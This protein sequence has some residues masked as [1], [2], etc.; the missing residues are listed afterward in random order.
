MSEVDQI[1]ASARG[2]IE[3]AQGGRAAG[4]ARARSVRGKHFAALRAHVWGKIGRIFVAAGAIL[5]GATLFGAFV[6]PLGFVGSLATL[7]LVGG[8]AMALAVFPR[9]KAPAPEDLTRTDIKAIAGQTEIWLES[10]RRALPAP[11]QTMVDAIGVQLDL[12]APQLQ[13]LDPQAP[14]AH[15]IRRLLA[16]DLTGLVAGYRAVP[17]PL[18]REGRNGGATPDAQLV[19][20]LKLIEREVGDMARGLAAGQLDQLATRQRY[21]EIKYQ[22]DGAAA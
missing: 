5:V 12:L 14:A 17:E 18:R 20:G 6:A 19:D 9:F 15:D 2:A 7:T 3:R 4:G 16:D 13:M 22:G 1:V 10:Q 21:L 8:A 11:A